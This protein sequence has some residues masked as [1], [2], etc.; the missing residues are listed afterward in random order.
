MIF[1]VFVANN[2][3]F[4]ACEKLTLMPGFMT[5]FTFKQGEKLIDRY[6]EISECFI[7]RTTVFVKLVNILAICWGIL[8]G[9]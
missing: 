4:M 5:F 7:F 9:A 8:I 1:K 2:D 3:V 6:K